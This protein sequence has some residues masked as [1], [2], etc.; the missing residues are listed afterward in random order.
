[1]AP[2]KIHHP[3]DSA[4][5]FSSSTSSFCLCFFLA[6]FCFSATRISLPLT[7]HFSPLFLAFP[8]LHLLLKIP[9]GFPRSFA[10]QIGE[11]EFTNI[12][13]EPLAH[14]YFLRSRSTHHCY[15]AFLDSFSETLS[16][17]ALFIHL[18]FL[19]TQGTPR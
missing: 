2:Y 15:F 12:G 4:F 13:K 10:A 11:E 5:I 1:M 7:G 16:Y 9:R 3:K 18:S 17:P 14:P 8:L 6:C 19:Y